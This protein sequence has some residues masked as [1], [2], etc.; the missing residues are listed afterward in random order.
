MRVARDEVS[1][2]GSLVQLNRFDVRLDDAEFPSD[3]CERVQSVLQVFLGVGRRH[4]GPAA[5]PCRAPTVGKP[6]ALGEDAL[7]RTACP[8]SSRPSPPRRRSPA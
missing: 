8:T 3:R 2:Y 6:D 7:G 4:D 5:A 1:A